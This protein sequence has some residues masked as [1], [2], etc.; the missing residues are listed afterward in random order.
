MNGNFL[1]L[2]QQVKEETT[3]NILAHFPD[4]ALKT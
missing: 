1:K 2:R 3:N 4:I